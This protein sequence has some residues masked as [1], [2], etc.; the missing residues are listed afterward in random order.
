VIHISNDPV[1]ARYGNDSLLTAP[2][3]PRI[4]P[5]ELLNE[6]L[7]PLW[8]LLKTRD[9]RG[10]FSRESVMWKAG[11][12]YSFHFGLCRNS[13]NVPLG[14]VLSQSTRDRMEAQLAQPKCG[15]LF[16]N[17]ANLRAIDAHFSPPERRL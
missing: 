14:W 2:D 8:A 6:A 9:A 11:W 17:P 4:A 12:S 3:N 13:T 15:E 5:K 10:F 7:S 1:E 16:D